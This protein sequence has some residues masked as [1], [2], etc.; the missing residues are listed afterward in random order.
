[1]DVKLTKAKF[2]KGAAKHR[3]PIYNPILPGKRI[4]QPSTMVK[5]REDLAA[6]H[7]DTLSTDTT[8]VVASYGSSTWYTALQSDS[9][10]E[11]S[12]GD[13]EDD[14]ND[15]KLNDSPEQSSVS[16]DITL[17]YR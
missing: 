11:S 17:G 14:E 8:R 4:L 15:P 1:M 9:S 7:E 13:V 12:A 6:A 3:K 5:L 10:G 2:K 16:E